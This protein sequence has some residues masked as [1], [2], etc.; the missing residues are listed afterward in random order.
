MPPGKGFYGRQ[1]RGGKSSERRMAPLYLLAALPVLGIVAWLGMAFLGGGDSTADPGAEAS[2]GSD[3][4]TGQ[5]KPT[6]PPIA[7]TRNPAIRAGGTNEG[8]A[9]LPANPPKPDIKEY[10]IAGGNRFELP[11]TAHAGVEDDFGTDRGGGLKHAG[12]YRQTAAYKSLN[13][14]GLLDSL[15]K[16]AISAGEQREEAKDVMEALR[17]LQDHGLSLAVAV[18]PPNQ[19]PPRAWGVIVVHQAAEGAEILSEL[20]K[21]IPGYEGRLGQTRLRGR[22]IK[23]L[24]IP[25]APVEVG[26][27]GEKGHLLIAF[28]MNAIQSGLDLADGR[29]RDV[30]HNPLWEKYGQ[31]NFE[32]AV[33]SAS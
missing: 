9:E 15:K 21:R 32:F 20:V 12:A 1:S 29:R 28:G 3:A 14:S 25:E 22:T 19:G 10:L 6:Q 8:T 5:P 4:Q 13:E 33:T 26:W 16:I 7:P 2:P 11:L 24:D 30:T 23:T 18:E 17:H 27:W 31:R